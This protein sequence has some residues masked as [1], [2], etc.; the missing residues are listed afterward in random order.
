MNNNKVRRLINES[1]KLLQ[2]SIML[3]AGNDELYYTA[4]EMADMFG[5]GN[6]H[7]SGM[8]HTSFERS[9]SGKDGNMRPDVRVA[10]IDSLEYAL[11]EPGLEDDYEADFVKLVKDTLAL[12]KNNKV[13]KVG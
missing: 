10:I 5:L 12:L 3:K 4:V 7:W 9:M 11:S 2:E 8:D 1:I 13:I 6:A